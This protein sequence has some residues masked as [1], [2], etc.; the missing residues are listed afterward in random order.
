MNSLRITG[1]KEFMKQLLCGYLFDEFD[2]KGACVTAAVTYQID[3]HRNQDYFDEEHVSNYIPFK[4][5]KSILF[6]MMKGYKAPLA[7]HL[8]LYLNSE[9][10]SSLDE[11]KSGL[12]QNSLISNCVLNI[13]FEN[14]IMDLITAIDYEMF[15]L[16]K[17][18][19][20]KWD[21][22]IYQI[23]KDNEISFQ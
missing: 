1:Q 12:I 20:K 9:S 5:V 8:V 18:V 17:E 22:Y 7:F 4:D 16:D 2:F 13:K 15:T 11:K 14:G 23:L 10:F 6:Q 21:R 3:G 19:E